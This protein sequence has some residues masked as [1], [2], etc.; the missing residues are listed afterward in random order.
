MQVEAID[1]ELRTSLWNVI[2]SFYW[3]KG[4]PDHLLEAKSNEV[5]LSL[6][7]TIWSGYL[8]LPNDTIGNRWG[9]PYG[10]LRTH[11][12][13]CPWNEDYDLIEFI[14]DNGMDKM[15]EQFRQECNRVLKR[16]SAGYRFVGDCIVQ[17]TAEEEIIEIEQALASKGRLQLVAI[18]LQTAIG[19]MSDRKSP[20][21]RNSIKE[22]ISAVEAIAKLI[23]KKDKSTL[24]EA[25]KVVTAKKVEM[26][27]ALSEAFTKLYGYT[28][29]ADGIRHSLMDESTLDFEDAKFMLVSCSAFVN[30]LKVKSSKVGINLETT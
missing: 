16:E 10:Q 13:S 28:S 27:P 19:L 12:F 14:A 1:D 6:L 25:L 5:V 9:K 7:K 22:S 8:K 17:I 11:Y 3:S 29:D 18:H 23:I 24:P 21:Y 20:E 4:N 26:H 2:D 30:Y 15:K